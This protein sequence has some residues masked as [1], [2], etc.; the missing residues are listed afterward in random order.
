MLHKEGS[1]VV[2]PRFV[3]LALTLAVMLAMFGIDFAFFR[4][5]IMQQYN[6]GLKIDWKLSIIESKTPPIIDSEF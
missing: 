3:D 1:R 4:I 5:N 2:L 6:F